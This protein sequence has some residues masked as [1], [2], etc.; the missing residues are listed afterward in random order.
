VKAALGHIE[1]AW[2]SQLDPDARRS[3]ETVIDLDAERLTCPAC[4]SEFD[5]GPRACPSCKL[6][7]Y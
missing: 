3:A 4:L 6:R 7:L 2:L 1:E 5:K